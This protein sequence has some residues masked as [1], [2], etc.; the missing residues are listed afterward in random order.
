MLDNINLIV[1]VNLCIAFNLSASAANISTL[2]KEQI[3]EI[4]GTAASCANNLPCCEGKKTNL[5]GSS[6]SQSHFVCQRLFKASANGLCLKAG[7]TWFG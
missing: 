1:S 5:S 4:H 2:S 3:Y 7:K 6:I